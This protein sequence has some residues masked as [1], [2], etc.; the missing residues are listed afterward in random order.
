[1][2]RGILNE[3][4]KNQIKYKRK[5]LFYSTRLSDAVDINSLND[6]EINV[7]FEIAYKHMRKYKRTYETNSKT[8]NIN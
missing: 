3:E 2:R 7:Y 4:S 6:Q 5:F 1:M 8:K